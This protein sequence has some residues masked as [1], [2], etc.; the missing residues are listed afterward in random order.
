MHL[1][2]YSLNQGLIGSASQKCWRGSFK[3][4]LLNSYGPRSQ[5]LYFSFGSNLKW[6]KHLNTVLQ[7]Y[8]APSRVTDQIHDLY[9]DSLKATVE[10]P[11]SS[12]EKLSWLSGGDSFST[13][14]QGFSTVAHF[15]WEKEFCFKK[16]GAKVSCEKVSVD[17]V[18]S[19]IRRSLHG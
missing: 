1:K 14:L 11:R 18:W 2:C 4:W 19:G 10:N 7:A 9:F 5:A 3:I 12:V 15:C 6:L 17:L 13:L 16:S 8:R